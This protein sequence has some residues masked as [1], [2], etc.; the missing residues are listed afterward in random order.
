MKLWMI[1]ARCDGMVWLVDS[2]D[3]D[4]VATNPEG[5][6]EAVAEARTA[7][8]ADNVSVVSTTVDF[9]AVLATFEAPTVRAAGIV[10]EE[11]AA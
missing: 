11:S 3:D 10:A 7:N 6:A 1:W 5:W 2:W 4:S 9:D 8:G